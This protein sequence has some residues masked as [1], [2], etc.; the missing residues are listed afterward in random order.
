[1]E[2]TCTDLCII[3]PNNVDLG[4][5]DSIYGSLLV[6]VPIFQLMP[7]WLNILIFKVWLYDKRD[8]FK[9][10]I[11]NFRVSPFISLTCYFYLFFETDHSLVSQPFLWIFI[12]SP[13]RDSFAPKDLPGSERASPSVKFPLTSMNQFSVQTKALYCTDLYNYQRDF[14]K[15]KK[16]K[17]CSYNRYNV[18]NYCLVCQACE[19]INCIGKYYD[20]FI[21]EQDCRQNK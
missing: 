14:F 9:F 3:S 18:S 16:M 21:N 8:D 10:A 7:F 1:M 4:R 12:C 13:C 2:E 20:P 17:S 6:F 11:F 19:M 15:K 5:R